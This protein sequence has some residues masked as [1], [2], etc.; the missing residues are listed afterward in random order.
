MGLRGSATCNTHTF[1]TAFLFSRESNHAFPQPPAVPP[2]A[3]APPRRLTRTSLPFF[4]LWRTVNVSGFN[5]SS[6]AQLLRV[7]EFAMARG[8]ARPAWYD[9]LRLVPPA[10]FPTRTEAADVAGLPKTKALPK[11]VF[12]QD[13]FYARIRHKFPQLQKEPFSLAHRRSVGA[14]P[15]RCCLP[16]RLTQPSH[17]HTFS[18]R[19]RVRFRT[20]AADFSQQTV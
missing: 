10:S 1:T 6:R 18:C 17:G 2:S 3:Q 5:M 11:I 7:A 19:S 20:A 16:S 8:G 4:L 14:A 9:G 15:A 12:E 13:A